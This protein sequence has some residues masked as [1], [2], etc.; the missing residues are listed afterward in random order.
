MCVYQQ[1]YANIISREVKQTS[2][3]IK[4]RAVLPDGVKYG[5]QCGKK[6]VKEVRKAR[7][8]ANGL[9]ISRKTP[10]A[11]R[12]TAAGLPQKILGRFVYSTTANLHAHMDISAHRRGQKQHIPLEVK[13]GV[14]FE[15]VLVIHCILNGSSAMRGDKHH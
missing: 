8:R 6:Q 2:A 5:P 13:E 15:S 3:C 1:V 12:H 10:H 4:C 14:P 9:G 11:A 7:K